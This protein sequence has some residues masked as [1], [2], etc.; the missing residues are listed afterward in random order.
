MYLRLGLDTDNWLATGLLTIT[1]RSAVLLVLYKFWKWF[2]RAVTGTTELLRICDYAVAKQAGR[3]AIGFVKLT[4]TI[5]NGVSNAVI[6]G[7]DKAETEKSPLIPSSSSSVSTPSAAGMNLQA[8]LIHRIDRCLLYSTKLILER[9]QLESKDCKVDETVT[10]IL[11]KKRFPNDGSP[12]SS[13]A[14]VLRASVSVIAASYKLMHDLNARA[15]TKYDSTN[16]AH[17]RKLMELWDMAMPNE[18]LTSRISDQWTKIGFQGSDPAT[19]F[20][21]MGYLFDAFEDAW[22]SN[23]TPL[24]VMDFG[25]FFGEF[26]GKIEKQLLEGSPLVLNDASSV[27]AKNK[28]KK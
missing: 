2:H 14:L 24:S 12:Q 7:D 27:F 28:K 11:I 1:Y 16:K 10:T 6:E 21:G 13:Q 8:S 15:A 25:R 22:T 19:D 9:R 3:Y 18:K 23:A 17:E 20:R 26:Q 4:P 5:T